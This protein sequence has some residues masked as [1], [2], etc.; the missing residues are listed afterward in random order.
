MVMRFWRWK[1][2]ACGVLEDRED[3][4]LPKGWIFVKGPTASHRCPSC[5]PEVPTHRRGS[6]KIVAEK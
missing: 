5:A 2:E 3:Y 1:C 6:Q 4:G